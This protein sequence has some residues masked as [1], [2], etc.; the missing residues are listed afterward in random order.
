M[1]III[2]INFIITVSL[3]ALGPNESVSISSRRQTFYRHGQEVLKFCFDEVWND[4]AL[5]KRRGS[6]LE[7]MI[8]F[9]KFHWRNDTKPL[10]GTVQLI[11]VTN[12]SSDVKIPVSTTLGKIQGLRRPEIPGPF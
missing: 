1:R 11:S 3:S 12:W 8:A 2:I 5:C 4:G 6:K 7:Q 10:T 9:G